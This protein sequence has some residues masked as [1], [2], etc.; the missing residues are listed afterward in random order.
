M[1]KRLELPKFQAFDAN[2]D[3][4]SGGLVYTYSAGTDTLKTTYS[5]YDASTANANPVVLNS[6]G[7]ADIYVQGSYKIVLKDSAGA[8]IWTLDNV[9][10][11]VGADAGGENFYYPEGTAADQGVT[12]STDTIKYAVDTISTNNGTIHLTHDSGASTTYTLTTSESIPKGIKI[13][14]ENGAIIDGA[15]T[16]TLDNPGQIVAGPNQ[17]VFGSSITVVFTT[18]GEAFSNWWYDGGTYSNVSIQAAIDAFSA[19]TGTVTMPAGTLQTNATITITTNGITLKGTGGIGNSHIANVENHTGTTIENKSGTDDAIIIGLDD[20]YMG[21]CILRDFA[22]DGDSATATAGNG[23]TLGTD[24]ATGGVSSVKLENISIHHADDYG[25]YLNGNVFEN[26]FHNVQ[27]RFNEEGIALGGVNGSTTQN[28]FYGCVAAKSTNYGVKDTGAS[29]ANSFYGC[30]FGENDIGMELS[31]GTC[32]SG[33]YV[34]NNDTTGIIITGSTCTIIGG[35]VSDTPT[36]VHFSDAA[37]SNSTLVGTYFNS[38]TTDILI[39]NG[40]R[41]SLILNPGSDTVTT[42]EVAITNSD[43]TSLILDQNWESLTAAGAART[44]GTTELNSTAGAMAVTLANGSFYGQKKRFFFDTDGG[45]VT[46]TVATHSLG[47]DVVF[48]FTTASDYLV[49]EWH[50]SQWITVV[51]AG[52]FFKGSDTWDPGAISDGNEEAKEV[53]VTG[54]ALGDFV[55]GSFSLDIT[56]LSLSCAVTAA[57]TVTCTLYNNTGGDINIGSGTISVEVI[58]KY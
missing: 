5:D 41:N 9:Q 1:T 37:A 28:Y 10:G 8:T 23:I 30:Y 18:G 3:P 43:R 45:D 39:A 27:L 32:V 54:A 13:I 47:T 38:N 56:D 19:S 50:Q 6:R 11:G 31:F 49:L 7:E 57:N 46:L 42:D 33:C 29:F 35:L 17:R 36:G 20:T 16:L 24:T 58:K 12:G 15:G 48:T 51:M 25:L 21:D 53:T 34:E 44:R 40:C 4:L 26:A 52:S 22:V 14:P 2:G 55:M